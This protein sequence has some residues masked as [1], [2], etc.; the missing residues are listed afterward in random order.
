[1]SNYQTAHTYLNTDGLTPRSARFQEVQLDPNARHDQLDFHPEPQSVPLLPPR[2]DDKGKQSSATRTRYPF[3]IQILRRIPLALGIVVSILLFILVVISS[4][5]PQAL[6]E[7]VLQDE[8]PLLSSETISTPF[9]IDYSD[10]ETFPLKPSEY[11]SECWK[12]LQAHPKH[13]GYWTAPPMGILDIEHTNDT[14]ATRHRCTSTMTYQLDDSVGLTA[15]L[16]FIAQLAA[17]ANEVRDFLT[18]TQPA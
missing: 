16:A 6:L 10:Y 9:R 1:M 13:Y 15:H 11:V 3:L 2:D 5:K 12:V 4:S 7:V 8:A 18:F 17:M 14:S